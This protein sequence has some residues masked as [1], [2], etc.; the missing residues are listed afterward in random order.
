LILFFDEGHGAAKRG[1]IVSTIGHT[2][3]FFE[4]HLMGK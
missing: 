3:A 1:N 4:K 2:I